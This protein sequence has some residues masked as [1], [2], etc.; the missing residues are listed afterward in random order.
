VPG[1]TSKT[2]SELTTSGV[3][4]AANYPEEAV[5]ARLADIL[6]ALTMRVDGNWIRMGSGEAGGISSVCSRLLSG[7][8]GTRVREA[9]ASESKSETDRCPIP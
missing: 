6:E 7:E 8:G 9:S 5:A 4:M 3:E 1:Y 2:R